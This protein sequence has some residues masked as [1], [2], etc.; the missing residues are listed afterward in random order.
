M[1]MM[2][3]I[4]SSHVSVSSIKK[5]LKKKEKEK[6]KSWCQIYNLW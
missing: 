5:I 3:S 1:T 6:E 4:F 2:I